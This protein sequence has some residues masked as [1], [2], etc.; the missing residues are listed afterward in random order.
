MRYL[1]SSVTLHRNQERPRDVAASST[2]STAP[3]PESVP[4]FNERRRLPQRPSMAASSRL[5]A[6]TLRGAAQASPSA[7][8]VR[9]ARGAGLA[10]IPLGA[11][12]L[13]PH[14]AQRFVA[15]FAQPER[16]GIPPDRLAQLMWLVFGPL[17][18]MPLPGEDQGLAVSRAA[19]GLRR[20]WSA[21][22]V[23]GLVGEPCNLHRAITRHP[24]LERQGVSD[25]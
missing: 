15:G 17:Q 3:T 13:P 22:H 18:R 9:P 2:C 14:H 11:T 10:R 23:A 5:T 21:S 16:A 6:A 7:H 4:A 8:S 20:V 25:E 24:A 12:A 19:V 1:S